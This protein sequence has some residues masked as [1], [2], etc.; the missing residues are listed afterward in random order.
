MTAS[1]RLTNFTLSKSLALA[2]KMAES[3]EQSPSSGQ[4][5][6]ICQLITIATFVNM[7]GGGIASKY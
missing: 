4:Q 6:L 2:S 3:I 7:V 5:G 1:G